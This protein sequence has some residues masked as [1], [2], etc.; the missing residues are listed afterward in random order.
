MKTAPEGGLAVVTGAAGGLGST[1]ARKLA[2]RGYRLLLIDR[3]QK[4]LDQVCESL[5]SHHGTGHHGICAEACAADLCN[6]D[7][8]ESLA[9][10]LRQLQDVAVLVNNAGFGAIDYFVDTDARC[11][12]EMACV[13]VV[14]PTLLTRAVLPGMIERNRGAIINLSSVAAWLPSAGNVQYGSTKCYLAVFSTALHQELR[15]TNVRVQALCPGLVRTEFHDADTMKAFNRRYTPAPHLWMSA[16]EVVNC[17][18]RRL[19]S[20][21][22]IVIPGLGYSVFGRLAQ[23]PVLQPLMQ[24]VTRGLRLSHSTGQAVEGC[25]APA[26]EVV[27]GA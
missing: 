23:M 3:R 1:F 17:S 15:G 10:R 26:L 4:Q 25:P 12:V 6:R 27:K 19:S 22:V 18:L 16:D 2:E 13:H 24:W 21:Q 11:L 7:E 9:A 5:T 14:A 8:L 20:K